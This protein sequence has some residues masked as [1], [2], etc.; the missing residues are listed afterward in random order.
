M[1]TMLAWFWIEDR[2]GEAGTR[3]TLKKLFRGE[4]P[5]SGYALLFVFAAFQLI[6]LFYRGD[7][8]LNGQGRIMSLHMFEAR[9][10]CEVLATVHW[11]TAPPTVVDLRMPELPPRIICDPIVYYSRVQNL[12]RSRDVD[13]HLLDVDFMMK[14]KRTTDPSFQTIVDEAS[15]C[16]VPH[17]YRVFANNSWIK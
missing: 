7:P 11:S 2:Y 5:L 17:R 6:P 12:C 14:V 4:A 1:T 9:Q 13:T 3:P 15:F 8:V 10:D 16:T